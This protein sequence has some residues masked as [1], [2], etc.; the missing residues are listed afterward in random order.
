[1]R[2]RCFQILMQG[3]RPHW[4]FRGLVNVHSRYGPPARRVTMRAVCLEGSDGFV[5]STRCF[6]RY[7]LERPSCRAGIAHNGEEHLSH[8]AQQA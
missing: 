7:R 6:D 4:S 8:G 5:S 3:R 1:M 2:T